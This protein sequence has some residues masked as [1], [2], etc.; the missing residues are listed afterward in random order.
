[1]NT[2]EQNNDLITKIPKIENDTENNNVVI[3]ESGLERLSSSSKFLTTMASW[4]GLINTKF[5]TDNATRLYVLAK[6][7]VTNGVGGCI[8]IFGDAYHLGK[9]YRD[10]GI[11]LR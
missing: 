1:M 10:L 4:I 7:K 5:I 6:D 9:A 8:K 3:N 2:I 11:S